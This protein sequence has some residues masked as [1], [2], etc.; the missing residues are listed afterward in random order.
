MKARFHVLIPL[1]LL[2]ALPLFAQRGEHEKNPPRANQGHVPPPPPRRES[3]RAKPEP[4]RH[5]GGRINN[6][7]T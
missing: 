5:D 6:H 2:A 4:E 7:R 3:P 1:A